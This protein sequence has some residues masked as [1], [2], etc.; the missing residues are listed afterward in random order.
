MAT[1]HKA[2]LISDHCEIALA[3]HI[4]A[5]VPDLALEMVG[6]LLYKHIG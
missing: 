6:S 2:A 1:Y 3:G 4:V 5:A